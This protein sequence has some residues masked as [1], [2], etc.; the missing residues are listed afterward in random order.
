MTKKYTVVMEL[1]VPKDEPKDIDSLIFN[2]KHHCQGDGIVVRCEVHDV[3][4]FE[5]LNK[6]A[7]N[8]IQNQA[9]EEIE[10]EILHGK[11]CIG[12]SC[13]D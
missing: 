11:Y 6:S 2:I 1:T 10:E 7:V 12:G 3:D 5:N 4:A 8:I 13:E 9:L